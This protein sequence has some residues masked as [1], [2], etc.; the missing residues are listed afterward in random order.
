VKAIE[1]LNSSKAITTGRESMKEP[2]ARKALSGLSRKE[3]HAAL[4]LIVHALEWDTGVD[5]VQGILTQQGMSDLHD[6][7]HDV[8]Y[9][10]Y[11][12]QISAK[13]M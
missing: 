5:L 4:T 13:P 9:A 1:I 6:R 11:A 12:G 2:Q 3:A 10:E 8:L 7:L